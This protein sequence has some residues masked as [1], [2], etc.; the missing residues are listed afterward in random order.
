MNEKVLQR[1]A[2]DLGGINSKAA[3]PPPQPAIDED[4]RSQ[5]K[6]VITTYFAGMTNMR[7]AEERAEQLAADNAILAARLEESQRALGEAERR[8]DAERLATIEA[9]R[10]ASRWQGLVEG[11][12]GAITKHV[13]TDGDDAAAAAA[14][15]A[16]AGQG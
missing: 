6:S 12:G 8:L 7:R 1:M 15:G 9:N 16:Q 4:F 11:L 2:E 10:R 13:T 14:N 5:M 3:S